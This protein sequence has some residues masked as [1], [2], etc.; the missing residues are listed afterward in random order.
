MD[1]LDDLDEYHTSVTHLYL[2]TQI[3]RDKGGR[4]DL[5]QFTLSAFEETGQAEST[6]PIL[7][8]Q[9]YTGERVITSALANS[10]WIDLGVDRVLGELNTKLGISYISMFPI[11]GL[12]PQG[13]DFGTTYAY[14]RPYWNR[15]TTIERELRTNEEEDKEMRRRV[16]VDGRITTRHVP[17]R[18]VWDLYANR[19]IPYWAACEYKWGISH[20]WV[21]EKDRKEVWTPINGYEWPVAMPKDANLDLIRIEMLNLGAEYAWLD[22]LCLRQEAEALKAG[23]TSICAW[24]SGSWMCPRSDG[25]MRRQKKWCA[26][27]MDWVGHCV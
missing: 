24:R 15:I 19:V 12:L 14:L 7:V 21:D 20:A 25:C 16:L 6:I 3:P 13:L 11:L 22:V 17:P 26:T 2:R 5:P 10:S 9:S 4:G 27:P 1:D 23:R 8:Q 18:R